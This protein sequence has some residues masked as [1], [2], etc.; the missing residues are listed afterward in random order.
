[1]L[2]F[3]SRLATLSR[4]SIVPPDPTEDRHG[5]AIVTIV[6]NESRYIGEWVSFHYKAGVRK[7]YIYDNGS[8]DDTVD[9]LYQSVPSDALVIT[10]WDQTLGDAR[11]K[12]TIHNQVLAYAHAA[13]NFGA[14]Y[15]WMAFRRS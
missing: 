15:R 10:P 11:Y 2:G 1:M 12:S 5:V 8:T 6:K 9:V 14:D 3:L 7:F 13:S 4:I